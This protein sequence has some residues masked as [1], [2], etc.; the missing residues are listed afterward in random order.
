MLKVDEATAEGARGLYQP[1]RSRTSKLYGL[2]KTEVG[3]NI[4]LKWIVRKNE[5]LRNLR[6][7]RLGSVKFIVY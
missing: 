5:S 4:L 6:G 1:E 2:T 3:C 7:D